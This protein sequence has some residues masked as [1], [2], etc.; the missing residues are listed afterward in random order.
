VNWRETGKR[1]GVRRR[2]LHLTPA[3]AAEG[4]NIPVKR[5]KDI[6]SGKANITLHELE[7][8]SD[9]LREPPYRLTGWRPAGQGIAYHMENTKAGCAVVI[10]FEK[11]YR[12]EN[13]KALPLDGYIRCDFEEVKE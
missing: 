12:L 2:E 6:E 3:R 11:S 7:K 1:I 4:A 10:E 13:V 8:I 9:V 5:W